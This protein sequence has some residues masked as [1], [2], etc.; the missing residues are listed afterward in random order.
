MDISA[1]VNLHRL[2]G[3]LLILAFVAFAI[4][5]SLPLVGERG[6]ARIYTLPE[7]DYLRAVADNPVAWRRGNVFMGA[8]GMLLLAGLSLLAT[9]LADAGERGFAALGVAGF[10]V[11]AL[12]W[13]TFC[14]FRATVTLHAAEEL[15]RTGAIPPYYEPLASW[16]G[17]LFY[18]YA[19]VGFL[20][21][22]AFGVS[23]LQVDLL[24]AWSGWGTIIFSVGLLIPLF[25]TGDTLPAFHYLPG[26]AI[27]LF[28]LL[29]G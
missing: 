29:R 15:T 10:L 24:P 17:A 12:L 26:L 11:A 7:S 4:G 28:L 18:V 6:E 19:V 14:A 13:V 9:I 22:A 25:V 3:A 5:A 23:L 1:L 16:S 20:A 2:A 27:G 8:A 21:L